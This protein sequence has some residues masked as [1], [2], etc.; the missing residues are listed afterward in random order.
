MRLVVSLMALFMLVA[1]DRD[2]QDDALAEDGSIKVLVDAR[3]LISSG[4]TATISDATGEILQIT[5]NFTSSESNTQLSIAAYSNN[6]ADVISPGEYE[7]GSKTAKTPYDGVCQ[8]VINDGNAPFSTTS[9][10][11]S[12]VGKVNITDLDRAGMYVSGTFEAT[13]GRNA[14]VKSLTKGSFTR[15][16]LAIN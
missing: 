8:Y 1:C 11:E 6:T 9:V 5:A 7:F 12:Y 14:E 10:P 3:T 15:I 2:D 4:V 13:V 16:K